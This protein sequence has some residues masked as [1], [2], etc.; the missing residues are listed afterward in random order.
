MTTSAAVTRPVDGPDTSPRTV[1]I[2]SLIG[3]TIEWYDFF[4]FATAAGI[5]FPQ[6]FYGDG[7]PTVAT[8]LSFATFA[9]GFVARPIGGLI[10]GH[11]GD[12]VGRRETLI[13]DTTTGEPK[14]VA[15]LPGN[16]GLPLPLAVA[17]STSFLAPLFGAYVLSGL[18]LVAVVIIAMIWAWRLGAKEI[19]GPVDAGL[20][21]TLPT[22]R[23]VPDPPGWWGSL[24]LL[25][26][27]GV[28][29]GSLLF[30]YAF[31][32]TIA[33]NWPP[34]TSLR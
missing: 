30:G 27:D 18:A 13:V 19:E 28:H 4:L 6:L 15:I 2:A 16:S 23:E 26:A 8:L 14:Q 10:F 11:I 29:F 22:S 34:P 7:D 24:M 9:I 12:R 21:L 33:P 20:G 25:L 5:V 17:T 3:T 1:L 32:F 31:L